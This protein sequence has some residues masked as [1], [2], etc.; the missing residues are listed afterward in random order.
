MLGLCIALGAG[1]CGGDGAA[2]PGTVDASVDTGAGPT[3]GQ[4][5]AAIDI[6]RA[7]EGTDGDAETGGVDMAIGGV[8]MAMD[9][10]RDAGEDTNR[11]NPGDEAR[12]SGGVVDGAAEVVAIGWDSGGTD[13]AD[14]DA[15]GPTELDAG[16]AC[17]TVDGGTVELPSAP[18]NVVFR[19]NVTVSTFAGGSSDSDLN[20]PVGIAITQDG[21]LVVSDYEDGLLRRVSSAGIVS[22]LT[23]QSSFTYPFA[24]AYDRNH[25]VIYATTD[26]DAQGTKNSSPRTTS[27]IWTIDPG[28]GV[29]S[30]IPVATDVGYMR[31][32]G[33][34]SD[35]RLVAADR[36]NHLIWIFDPTA[37]TKAVLAGSAACVGGSNGT[38]PGAEFTEPYGLAVLPDDSVVVADYGLRVLRRVTTAGEVT[39]FAGDGGPAGTIDGP[40]LSA[41]FN[42][43]Q[44]VAAD[45]QGVVYVSDTSAHRIRRIGVDGMVTTLAGDGTQGYADGANDVAEFFAGEGIAA[46]ADGS[47]VYVADGTLGTDTPV[48]YHRIRKIAIGP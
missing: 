26:A 3:T 19:P 24:L 31:G 34:L 2:R 28:S 29:A 43:P 38:G 18:D 6:R 7:V 5:D 48:P 27:T 8:D 33:V 12:G 45:A 37:G 11:D 1:S 30:N 40:A 16:F 44:A 42:R 25:H 4:V 36:T 15:P 41:R 21:E 23:Q 17:P 20:N 47:A 14:V 9:Q 13:G 35:G 39:T 32:V 46:S 10:A 22:I